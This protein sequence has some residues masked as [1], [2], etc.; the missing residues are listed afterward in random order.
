MWWDLVAGARMNV[1]RPQEDGRRSPRRDLELGG[2]FSLE[3]KSR[4]K[5]S[6][7]TA[8]K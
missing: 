8:R 7:T 6:G 2:M 1:Y 4:C 5:S 3:G